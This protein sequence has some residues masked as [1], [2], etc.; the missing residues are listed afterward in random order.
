MGFAGLTCLP[1]DYKPDGALENLEKKHNFIS[2]T[3]HTECGSTYKVNNDTEVLVEKPGADCLVQ[4]AFTNFIYS[5]TFDERYRVSG[6]SKLL[7][8]FNLKNFR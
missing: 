6:N 7:G 4:N 3:F 5:E 1:K 2:K 8:S